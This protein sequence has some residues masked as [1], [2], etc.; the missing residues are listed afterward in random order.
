MDFFF[1]HRSLLSIWIL[2]NIGFTGH[3]Y[4]AAQA[5][6]YWVR[7]DGINIHII[8][9]MILGVDLCNNIWNLIARS[10]INS[11]SFVTK[12]RTDKLTF[13]PIVYNGFMLLFS[14]NSYL[15]HKSKE[16]RNFNK[17]ILNFFC[18]DDSS[19]RWW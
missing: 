7:S 8:I 15:F 9:V 13:Y 2:L 18:T 10:S 4:L 16:E 1:K 3:L 5:F 14:L 11:F 17:Y 6:I 12:Q 19:F